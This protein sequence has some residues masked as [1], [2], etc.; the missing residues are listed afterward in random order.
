[1]SRSPMEN[2]NDW[3]AADV[4]TSGSVGEM[5]TASAASDPNDFVRYAQVG[6]PVTGLKP[7]KCP[8]CDGRGIVFSGFYDFDREVIETDPQCRSCKGAGYLLVM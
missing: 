7:H 8:V 2:M 6:E 1:M 3:E 5:G 4:T